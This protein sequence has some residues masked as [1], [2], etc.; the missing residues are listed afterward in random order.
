MAGL[1]GDFPFVAMIQREVVSHQ[2]GRCPGSGAV[3]SFTFQAKLPGVNDGFFV[4]VG[5]GA[6][7][8][9]KLLFGVATLA[10]GFFVR[11]IQDKDQVVVEVGGFAAP[12]VALQAGEAKQVNVFGHERRIGL[13]MTGL[14]IYGVN[15]VNRLFMAVV[16]GH[17]RLIEIGLVGHQAEIGEAIMVEEAERH[18]GDFGLVSGVVG[19]TGLAS[20]GVYE[21][22]V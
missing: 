22:A 4:T 2:L 11:P 9:L 20:L 16:A 8:V 15:G 17:F 13:G 7:C 12:L 6:G 21:L 14:T 18:A 19:V 10:G 3:A 1:A 5:T